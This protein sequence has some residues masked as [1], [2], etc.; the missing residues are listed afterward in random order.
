MYLANWVSLSYRLSIWCLLAGIFVDA[1]AKSVLI[2]RRVAER[3]LFVFAL[4]NYPL[5][6]WCGRPVWKMDSN[7]TTK[8]KPVKLNFTILAPYTIVYWITRLHQVATLDFQHR[9]LNFGGNECYQ[10]TFNYYRYRNIPF[11]PWNVYVCALRMRCM[12]GYLVTLVQKRLMAQRARDIRSNFDDYALSFQRCIS[13][14]LRERGGE[15]LIL[16]LSTWVPEQS[17]NALKAMA[18]QQRF[19]RT[20]DVQGK[21]PKLENAHRSIFYNVKMFHAENQL[22]VAKD[23]VQ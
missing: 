20:W 4:Q 23:S 16:N 10:N 7:C 5:F 19:A 17:E 11:I 15:Y 12:C 3:P 2:S 1:R 18:F 14:S 6:V 13:S 9:R 8:V 22:R 21:T